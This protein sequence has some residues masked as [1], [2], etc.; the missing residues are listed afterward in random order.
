[1]CTSR[2]ESSLSHGGASGSTSASYE[3]GA[4]NGSSSL[5][6]ILHG[7]TG[8]AASTGHAVVNTSRLHEMIAAPR[9]SAADRLRTRS[10][11]PLMRQALTYSSTHRQTVVS[12][13]SDRPAAVTSSS[14]LSEPVRQSAL[15]RQ[16]YLYQLVSDAERSSRP[17]SKPA[18][19]TGD[20]YQLSTASRQHDA[21]PPPPTDDQLQLLHHDRDDD[22]AVSY[23]HLTLPTKRI[24]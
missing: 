23:T 12:T 13:A 8:T 1:M 19:H 9:S 11:S 14:L 3:L 20:K 22:D 4:V 16:S 2:S 7:P 17:V 15:S 5:S 21:F 18:K 10:Y 24:V 6:S